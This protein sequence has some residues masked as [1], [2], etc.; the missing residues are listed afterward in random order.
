MDTASRPNPLAFLDDEL[1][2]LRERHLY[3]P[4]R[5]MSS[6]QGPIVSIDDRRVISLSLQR[7]PRPVAPPAH[8]AGGDRGRRALR[9]GLG[10]GA[11]DRRDDDGPR[12]ARGGPRGV[13]AHRGGPDV[14]V[15]VRVQHGRH[16]HDHR[17]DRPDRLRRAQPRLDHRRHAAVEGAAQGLPARRRRLAARGPRGR[18]RARPRR[19][20][21]AVPA[22][23]RRHRR[24]VQHG[25]RHRAAARRSSTSPR[26]SGPRSWSTTR[27]RRGCS[28]RP[29]AGR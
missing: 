25:R 13:Q 1:A 16:P 20:R 9:R 22:D 2:A 23:P 14:P 11:D 5:V 8:E 27:T 3:R 7:L 26:R 21:R 19:Q 4:L 28:A 10:G 15:R 29:A 17:R 6:A 12:G 18:D 24:R